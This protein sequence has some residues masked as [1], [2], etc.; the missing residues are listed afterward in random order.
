M[1]FTPNQAI[2]NYVR[3]LTENSNQLILNPSVRMQLGATQLPD[4]S[5][6]LPSEINDLVRNYNKTLSNIIDRHGPLKTK[7]VRARPKV[8]WYNADI[9]AAKCVET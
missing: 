3:S 5:T 6:C 7:I 1:Q 8:P 2:H 4:E 9:D